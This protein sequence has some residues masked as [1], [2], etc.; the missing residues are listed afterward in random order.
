MIEPNKFKW[1][2]GLPNKLE[3]WSTL[4]SLISHFESSA[5]K[6]GDLI[7]EKVNK[8]ITL[9][10]KLLV[11]V[12]NTVFINEHNYTCNTHSAEEGKMNRLI[13]HVKEQLELVRF[14]HPRYSSTILKY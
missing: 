3:S 6:P 7:N 11:E 8:V 1:I 13:T 2:F 9:C 5:D 12:N 4:T 14:N 10:K